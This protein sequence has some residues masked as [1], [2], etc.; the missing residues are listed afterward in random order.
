MNT[1]RNLQ[2]LGTHIINKKNPAVICMFNYLDNVN[3]FVF[4]LAII[5]FYRIGCYVN[6]ISPFPHFYFFHNLFI[7]ISIIAF[8]SVRY[9]QVQMTELRR[10]MSGDNNLHLINDKMSR[11]QLSILNIIVPPI[12]GSFFGGLA[13]LLVN[14]DIKKI[15]A[16]F[17]IIVYAFCVYISFLGYLQ[18]I[19]LCVYI[20]RIGKNKHICKY[21]E[22]FPSNTEWL[23]TLTKLYC[24]Y[25]NT[26][27]VLGTMY[28]LGVIYFVLCK[29]FK[30]IEK[31]NTFPN[32]RIALLL[33]WGGVL[34]AIVIL[35]PCISIIEY[36]YIHKIVDNLKEESVS[37]INKW[38]FNNEDL[39][40]KLEKSNLVIAIRNTPDYPVKDVI[41]II[42][43]C[44]VT[45]IN[46]A[47][48]ISAIFQVASI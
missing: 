25:R 40:L 46:L 21:D 7:V 17:L 32:F 43:S 34:C 18:Y 24:R 2:H 31:L 1:I 37:K 33:F 10:M 23:T 29:D 16:Y 19:Y 42:F 26:F 27:F 22:D 35:F 28:V 20:I 44:I 39:K 30:V 12:A 8:I 3:I 38:V 11:L 15:S 45:C 9:F 13:I 41:G 36:V 47:A 5:L 4:S 6:Y 14:I 48:S